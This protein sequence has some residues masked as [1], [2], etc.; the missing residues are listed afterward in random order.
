MTPPRAENCV[1]GRNT[2]SCQR[3]CKIWSIG[4]CAPMA[5]CISCRCGQR[6]NSTTLI[7]AWPSPNSCDCS[8]TSMGCH[9]VTLGPFAVRSFSYTNHTLLPE[10]LETWPMELF[11]RV[12]P[13]HL[14]IIYRINAEHLEH[15][16]QQD[17]VV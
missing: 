11:E 17:P 1:Y 9:G 3:R 7:P 8:S 15:A 10:A 13:R 5:I 6:S 4:I 2:S 14:Q 16:K 12:L